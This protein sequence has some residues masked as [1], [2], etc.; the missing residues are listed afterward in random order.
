[1]W[2]Q[3]CSRKEGRELLER[4]RLEFSDKISG[5]NS[6]LSLAEN[7]TLERLSREGITSLHAFF[8]SNTSISNASLK[9]AKN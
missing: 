1:M 9:F 5:N 3:I 8:I 7:Y 2:T 4:S 6:A